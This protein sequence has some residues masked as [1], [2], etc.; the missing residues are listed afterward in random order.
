M[1]N[2]LTRSSYY[3][4]ASPS[5]AT[6]LLLKCKTYLKDDFSLYFQEK[7]NIVNVASKNVMSMYIIAVLF[8]KLCSENQL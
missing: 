2:Y 3:N 6:F 8:Y 4:V 7:G 1:E 5:T